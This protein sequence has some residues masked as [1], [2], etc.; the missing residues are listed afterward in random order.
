M[1]NFRGVNGMVLR[2]SPLFEPAF[3]QEVSH[4]LALHRGVAAVSRGAGPGPLDGSFESG[5][6]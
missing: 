1:F 5:E 4:A 2:V 6:V 3:F